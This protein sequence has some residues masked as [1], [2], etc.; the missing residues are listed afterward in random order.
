MEAEEEEERREAAIAVTPALQPNFQS[1]S[2]TKE[3]L[4]K[5]KELHRRRL[6]IK[7]RSKFHNNSKG[8]SSGAAKAYEQELDSKD[9]RDEDIAITLEDSSVSMSEGNKNISSLKKGKVEAS[10]TPKKRQKLHW[11]LDTKERWER[12]ANM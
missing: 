9:S 7:A 3:Q 2:V 8:H 6:Q 11:G 12:K 4:D 1:A 10:S 5:F